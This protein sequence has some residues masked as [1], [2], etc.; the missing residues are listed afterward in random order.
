MEITLHLTDGEADALRRRARSEGC[1]P[2][3]LARKAL[4]ER[5]EDDA[6]RRPPVD[7]VLDEQLP[8]LTEAQRRLDR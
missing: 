2:Q 1:S 8:R 3:E 7:E 4:L 5:L 6:D